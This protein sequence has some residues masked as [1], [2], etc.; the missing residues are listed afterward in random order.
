MHTM[1]KDFSMNYVVFG[2]TLFFH[3]FTPSSWTMANWGWFSWMSGLDIPGIL[4][5]KY[6][7]EYSIP[8]VIAIFLIKHFRISERIVDPLPG[9]ELILI[10]GLIYVAPDI[11]RCISA[12]FFVDITRSL[13]YS[14]TT[15]G[16][17]ILL[18]LGLFYF[19][20]NLKSMPPINIKHNNSKQQGPAA[21]TR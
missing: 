5:I 3:L 8:F 2:L 16:L 18:G 17:K 13:L 14:Y 19:F 11:I 12:E 20:I 4:I 7:I 9:K 21:G 1:E 10:G 15:K 6:A